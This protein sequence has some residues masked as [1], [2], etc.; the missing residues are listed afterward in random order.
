[1]TDTPKTHSVGIELNSR[2]LPL[3]YAQRKALNEPLLVVHKDGEEGGLLIGR[4]N[5]EVFMDGFDKPE[6]ASG[7]FRA[8]LNERKKFYADRLGEAFAASIQFPD[9]LNAEDLAWDA[10]DEELQEMEPIPASNEFRHQ[11][12]DAALQEAGIDLGLASET[13]EITG[14]GWKAIAADF[15]LDRERT[16]EQAAALDRAATSG[17]APVKTGTKD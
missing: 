10:L 14:E 12:L 17:F 13:G 4:L 9:A 1:M 16:P 6:W 8:D 15:D 3:P 11:V 5:G 7:Y 2:T